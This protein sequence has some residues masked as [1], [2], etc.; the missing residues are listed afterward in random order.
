MGE[1]TKREKVFMTLN[2]KKTGYIPFIPSATTFALQRSVYSA[3]ECRKDP[4]KFTEAMVTA[5]REFGYDGLWAGLFQGV[6]SSMGQGL[7][8]KH[9]KKSTTGDATVHEPADLAKLRPFTPADCEPLQIILETIALLKKTE[10]D[11]PV[12]VIMD[13]PSMV[14][15]ALMDGAN[16]YYNLINN[17]SFVHDLTEMVFEPLVKCAEIIIKAGADILWLPLPTIGGTCISRQHYAEFCL[18]YNRRFN[19]IITNKGAH[20]I[21]HTCGN[22]ND[23]FDLATAEGAHCLHVAEADLRQL[24][25]DYG[26][27]TAFMGQ[28]PS[29]STLM[30]GTPEQIFQEGIRECLLAAE[31]GGFILSADCGMP[32]QTPA[33]NVH[34]LVAAARE[35]EKLLSGNC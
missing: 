33:A 1:L 29:V 28:V 11:E 32:A 13:N 34:A 31:G 4:V 25:E 35:A 17:P 10:T 9:G 26:H 12:L 3:A 16:Y 6:T 30:L 5:R 8:D 15:A 2:R 27:Q 7:I 19:E 22:W 20:L 18:P 24:K 21:V 14:A 23:R